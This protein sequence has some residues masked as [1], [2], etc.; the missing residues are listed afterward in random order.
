VL[1]YELKNKTAG[2][3]VKCRLRQYRFTCKQGFANSPRY[4]RS[5]G[6]V[7]IVSVAE[8]ND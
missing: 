2:T 3:K 4:V 5:P 7:M 6:M 8:S 1:V